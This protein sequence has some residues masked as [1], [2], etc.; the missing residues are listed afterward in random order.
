MKAIYD[1]DQSDRQSPHVNWNTVSA[2]DAKRRAEVRTLLDA[3]KLHTGEDFREAAFIFQH[4]DKAGDYLLAHVLAMA[5]MSKGDPTAA[6]IAA[7]TLD[8]YLQAAGKAQI[9]G[10]QFVL[11][12]DG[13]K[14]TAPSQPYDSKLLPPA[15]LGQ[16]G[17]SR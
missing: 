11:K 5:A 13:G 7:A 6:W 17:T 2:A 4:G 16:F 1:A 14:A 15:L 3:G 8:R 9:F 10:T 12:R